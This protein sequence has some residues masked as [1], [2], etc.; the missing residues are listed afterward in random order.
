MVAKLQAPIVLQGYQ[1][2]SSDLLRCLFSVCSISKM[3]LAKCI[4]IFP[5][6]A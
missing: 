1:V 4:V 6:I 2:E 5:V 3:L